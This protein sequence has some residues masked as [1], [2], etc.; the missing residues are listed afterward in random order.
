MCIRDRFCAAQPKQAAKA[1]S[2][3]LKRAIEA[4]VV[5]YAAGSIEKAGTPFAENFLLDTP[6]KLR[7]AELA[8]WKQRLGEARLE[9]ID[10]M[11]ALA[12]KFTLICERGRLTGTIILSPDAEPGIQKLTFAIA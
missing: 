11:H 10:P 1:S 5:A 2:P 6:P 3:W 12:G 4:V 8:R 7:D 9:A